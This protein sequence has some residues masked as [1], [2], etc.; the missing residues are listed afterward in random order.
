[1][2]VQGANTSAG[3]PAAAAVFK[4]LGPGPAESDTKSLAAQLSWEFPGSKLR[5]AHEDEDKQSAK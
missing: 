3:L 5:Q 2:Q 1:M 4:K